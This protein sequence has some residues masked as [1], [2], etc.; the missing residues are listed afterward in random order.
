MRDGSSRDDVRP[1]SFSNPALVEYEGSGLVAGAGTGVER[2]VLATGFTSSSSDSSELDSSSLLDSD[3]SF[4]S[5][6]CKNLLWN[7]FFSG[8]VVLEEAVVGRTLTGVSAG[9]TSAGFATAGEVPEL[10]DDDDSTLA[11]RTGFL[12]AGTGV[13]DFDCCWLDNAVS[14]SSAWISTFMIK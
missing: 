9:F 5:V 1:A 12:P 2:V 7:G 6:G 8:S 11:A 14:V 10:S 13:E 3:S 4:F